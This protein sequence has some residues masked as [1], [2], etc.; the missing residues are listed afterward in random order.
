MPPMDSLMTLLSAAALATAVGAVVVA[1]VAAAATRRSYKAAVMRGARPTAPGQRIRELISRLTEASKR[2]D[3]AIEEIAE[4]V[5]GREAALE[6][7]RE[8]NEA[9]LRQEAELER[10]VATL[11]DVPVEVG[12]YFEKISRA[13][14]ERAHRRGVWVSLVLLCRGCGRD[15]GDKPGLLGTAFALGG[16]C[17]RPAPR[18]RTIWPFWRRSG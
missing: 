7:L 13:H 10:R 5:A 4:E 17:E 1:A 8:R 14:A 11:K 6:R 12:Q 15:D 16:G 18:W 9:L 2:V 3:A